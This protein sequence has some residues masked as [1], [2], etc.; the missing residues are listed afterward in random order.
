MVSV[1]FVSF[2][3]AGI[4]DTRR[5][6]RFLFRHLYR[7]EREQSVPGRFDS[8]KGGKE[9]RMNGEWE[10]GPIQGRFL[11]PVSKLPCASDIS[12]DPLLL[13]HWNGT[14]IVSELVVPRSDFRKEKCKTNGWIGIGWPLMSNK[15][16]SGIQFLSS[17][18]RALFLS[19]YSF[20]PLPPPIPS[21][22]LSISFES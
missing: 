1:H 4:V 5:T 18:A 22:H 10:W 20:H 3:F 19:F 17:N 12:I 16:K 2:H 11:L 21:H 6:R 15:T 13:F 7:N 8:G 14:Y 9:V